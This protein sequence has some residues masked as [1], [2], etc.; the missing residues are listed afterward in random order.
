MSK[1]YRNLKFDTDDSYA[2]EASR[3]KNLR[4]NEDSHQYIQ[5]VHNK[6]DNLRKAKERKKYSAFTH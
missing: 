1:D 3:K 5:K 4:M 2:D 6:R